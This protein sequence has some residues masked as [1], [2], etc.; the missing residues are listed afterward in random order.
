MTDILDIVF[1]IFELS[2]ENLLF[3]GVFELEILTILDRDSFGICL[4]ILL[5]LG[6][7]VFLSVDEDLEL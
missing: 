1:K 6:L 7:I 5:Y 2:F 4:L 3:L